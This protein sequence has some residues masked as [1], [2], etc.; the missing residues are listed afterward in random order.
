MPLSDSTKKYLGEVKKGQPCEFVMICK[1][2]K[3]LNLIVYKFGNENTF[4]KKAK[5]EGNGKF[6]ARCDHWKSDERYFPVGE[7]SLRK[8]PGKKLVLKE[9]LEREAEMKFKPKY[10]IVDSLTEI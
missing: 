4:K 2:V 5:E 8:V 6:Y 10:E 3:I 1:G 7:G 9:F